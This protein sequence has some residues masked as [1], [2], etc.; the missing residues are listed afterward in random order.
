ML[1]F[2]AIDVET[3]NADRASICQIGIVHVRDGEIEDRW[4]TLVDPEDWF[5][6]WNVSIHGIDEDDVW[7]SPTLP[8][9]RAELR[10]R[11]R[12]SVL[13][14]HTSFDRVA[15]ER[16]MTRYGL[17]QLQVTWLDS[18]KIARRAWPDRYGRRGYGLKN[19][20]RDLD[21]SFRHHDAL[22]D[23][24]AAAE[25]VLRACS[26]A[27]MDIEGWLRRV[28]RPVFPASSGSSS[29]SRASANREG[30]ADGALFGETIVFTGAL[31]IKRKVAADMAAGAGCGVADNV[32]K[33][34]TMVVV[35]TQDKSKLKGYAKSGK[36][37]KAEALIGKGVEIQILSESDFS[38]LIG[39]DLVR[40]DERATPGLEEV[41]R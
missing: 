2:N 41:V 22:E 26:A 11:L 15:F 17:E 27:E 32:S 21:I 9:V 38:E 3:A 20:A 31:A 36:H 10:A 37:R 29:G 25:I 14:S 12:G 13:V 28:E 6:P 7:Q 5:D 30:N 39:V 24:R 40:G 18:A 4:Q 23:A 19:V 8:E 34:V 16:A 33:K 1:T 35:G